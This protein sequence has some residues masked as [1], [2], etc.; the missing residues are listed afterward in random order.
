MTLGSLL[1]VLAGLMVFAGFFF[2]LGV[3]AAFTPMTVDIVLM[4]IGP[5]V[6]FAAVVYAVSRFPG[7]FLVIGPLMFV[8]AVDAAAI[9]NYVPYGLGIG[10]LSEVKYGS[11]DHPGV[12]LLWFGIFWIFLPGAVVVG[13]AAG[14]LASAI[15]WFGGGLRRV[16]TPSPRGD[17]SPSGTPGHR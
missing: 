2:A 5:L 10:D 4:V 1:T 15:L 6:C 16:M 14:I 17:A 3:T 8:I 9:G 11:D 13:V 7:R 12:S